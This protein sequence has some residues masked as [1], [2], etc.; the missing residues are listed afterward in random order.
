MFYRINDTRTLVNRVLMRDRGMSKLGRRSLVKCMINTTEEVIENDVYITFYFRNIEFEGQIDWGIYWNQ[1]FN[2]NES[3]DKGSETA[4]GVILIET[5]NCL[6][7]VSHGKAF[8]YIQKLAD[9]DFGLDV[10]EIFLDESQ[11]NIKSAKYFKK[12]KNKSLTQYNDESYVTS[13][14][15]ESDEFVVGKCTFNTKYENFK[16]YKYKDLMKFGHSVKLT[17]GE[18]APSEIVQIICE[19]EYIK[20]NTTPEEKLCNLPRLLFVKNTIDNEPK[21]TDLNAKLLKDITKSVNVITTLSYYVIAG[22]DVV[23]TPNEYGNVDLLYKKRYPIDFNMISIKNMLIV[24]ECDDIGKVTIVNNETDDRIKLMNIMDFTTKYHGENYCLYNG[25]WAKFNASFMD[26]IKRDIKLV[27]SCAVYDP[28]YN[29]T[30]D[31]LK[32]GNL[33]R[34]Q[35]YPN[36]NVTYTEFNYNVYHDDRLNSK[37]LDR[38]SVEGDFSSVEFADLFFEDEMSLVHV[39]IGDTASLRY[40]VEQSRRTAEIFRSHD[41]YL[42]S[43]DIHEVKQ[44]CMLFVSKVKSIIDGDNI[45]LQNSNSIYFRVELIEWWNTIRNLGYEPKIIVAKDL[46]RNS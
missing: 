10:A 24:S 20:N 27:N 31:V 3:F 40:C 36:N 42:E 13:E 8:S 12:S 9:D 2:S 46:R 5:S 44:I 41:D 43:R 22:G 37:L 11:I 23:I 35:R 14:I 1:I 29:L 18:F 38:D 16:L 34:K 28:E 17:V 45:K 19:I 39:K 26:Y 15:G 4:F 33:I 6:Y 21:I 32:K 7:A 30:N 25:K